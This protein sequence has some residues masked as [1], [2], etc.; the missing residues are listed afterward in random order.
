MPV[1][2]GCI[3]DAVGEV[4]CA[5]G[6]DGTHEVRTR[7]VVHDSRRDHAMVPGPDRAVREQG[8]DAM[9]RCRPVEVV[10]EIVLAA[11]DELHRD[12]EA[13]CDRDGLEHLF[14]HH[15]PAEPSAHEH[16]V[17]DHAVPGDAERARGRLLHG[18]R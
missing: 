16:G 13:P 12:V 1:L 9:V 18:L 7:I 10:L 17:H 6:A 8:V 11:P 15:A 4:G 2:D 3:G 14:V 5:F